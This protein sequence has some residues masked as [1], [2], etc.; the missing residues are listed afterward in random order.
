[1]IEVSGLSK[2]YGD[3]VAL[4]NVSF[5]VNEGEIVGFLGPNGAGKTTT[6]NILTGYISSNEGKV[7]VDGYDVLDEPNKAKAN[8]G[9]L[10]EHPPLYK[11]MTVK[12]YLGFVYDL[13]QCKLPKS[14]HLREIADLIKIDSVYTRVIGHLSKGFQQRVGL[15]AALVGDPKI[16]ILDEPTVGLDPKQII[17]IRG[18]IKKLG[19]TRTVMLSSHILPEVQAICERI[20]IINY[21]EL[22][23]DDTPENL[24]KILSSDYQ[25]TLKIRGPENEVFSVLSSTVGVEK[26]LSRGEVETGVY[27]FEIIP[28]KDRD[29]RADIFKRMAERNWAIYGM[30]DSLMTL[31]D[32][33]LRLISQD[34][35][36]IYKQ[37]E[38]NKLKKKTSEQ[39]GDDYFEKNEAE[40]DSED[41]ILENDE[42]FESDESG[43]DE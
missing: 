42:F 14:R 40:Q 31:E 32:I 37:A 19:K 2:R 38:I 26:V 25:C 34:G 6:M 15:A 36:E 4:N 35:A 33:F 39:D 13:K 21:G 11:D 1:M 20:I 16:L 12:A 29:T 27:K 17:E 41:E 22:V 30:Q 3:K 24:S 18:L 23:A 5:K 28:K 7:T 43:E 10:P 8:V 9:Y